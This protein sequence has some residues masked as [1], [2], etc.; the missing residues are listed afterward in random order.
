MTDQAKLIK[1]RSR[2]DTIMEHREKDLKVLV[3]EK[4]D[5]LKSVAKRIKEVRLRCGAAPLV[6]YP[7]KVDS[8][9]LAA[10]QK[11]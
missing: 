2:N 6:I 11:Q 9:S 7:N 8:L 5:E 1:P 3:D 4:K 10:E